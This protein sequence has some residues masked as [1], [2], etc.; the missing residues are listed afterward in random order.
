MEAFIKIPNAILQDKDLN[1][2]QMILYGYIRGLS[3]KKWYCYASN[4]TL[5][6]YLNIKIRAVQ[7]HLNKLKERWYI[8]IEMEWYFD[9]KITYVKKNMGDVKNDMGGVSEMTPYIMSEMTPYIDKEKDNINKEI[10][11]EFETFRKL[12]P[13]ARKWKK[14]EAK[15]F[16]TQINDPVTV[17]KEVKHLKL[18]IQ[19]WIEEIKF[20]PACERWIRDFTPISDEVKVKDLEKIMKRHLTTEWTKERYPDLVEV[21]GEERVKAMAKKISKTLDLNKQKDVQI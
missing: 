8:E 18:K 19:A 16:Y 3:L 21:Y 6:E 11:K 5:W 1:H 10:N 17:I 14:Q 12:F 13:H 2:T 20:I 4:K 7:R 9:R 15:K